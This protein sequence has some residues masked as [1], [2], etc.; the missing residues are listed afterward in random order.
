MHDF[1]AGKCDLVAGNCMVQQ[2]FNCRNF[3]PPISSC[4]SLLHALSAG[5]GIFDAKDCMGQ[6]TFHDEL[7]CR[8]FQPSK[9]DSKP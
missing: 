8:K 5:N 1:S 4:S 7:F 6:Q 3:Q 2:G 9:E